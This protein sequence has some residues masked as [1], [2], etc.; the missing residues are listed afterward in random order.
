MGLGTVR[1][2]APQGTFDIVLANI[3]KNV[4]LDELEIYASLVK[5]Q[6]N[7]LLSGFYTH[8]IEDIHEKAKSVGFKLLSQKDKDNWAALI[9][10]KI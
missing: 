6:G 2:V 5:K 8:D 7:L 10:E 3:N 4:L 1:E 9:F